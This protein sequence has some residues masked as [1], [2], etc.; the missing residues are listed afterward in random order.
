MYMYIGRTE[1][2]LATRV[3]EHL[4]KWVLSDHTRSKNIHP[5]G[6]ITRHVLICQLSDTTIPA[7]A[8]FSAASSENLV[9]EVLYLKYGK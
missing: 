1:R 9:C 6:A 5:N 3:A 4:P 2:T 7:P 8:F